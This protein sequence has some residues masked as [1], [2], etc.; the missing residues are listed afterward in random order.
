MK[1]EQEHSKQNNDAPKDPKL[2]SDH[3]YD[4]IQ[5]LNNPAPFWIAAIFI[6]TIVFSMFY[7]IQNFGYP[8][9]G[10]DQAS[11]YE[12]K[13]AEFEIKKAEMRMAAMGEGAELDP[14]LM[15][16]EGAKLYNEKGCMVCHGSQG[17]GNNIGPNL[18]DNFWLNGCTP[19]DVAK[20][21]AEGKP[22]KGMTPY[23]SVM[24]E[25]QIKYLSKHIL[26]TLVGSNPTNPKD[27]EGEEC[28]D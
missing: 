16:K 10:N 28:I 22:A 27:P 23:K 17:E 11:R 13:V 8:N 12:R 2:M 24:T 18:T 19:E 21:I 5:E 25:D 4:G 7:V 1:E 15:L 6:V 3:D 14:V 26:E 20:I 9:Q